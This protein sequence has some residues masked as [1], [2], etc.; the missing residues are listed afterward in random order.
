M[1]KKWK[2]R[3]RGLAALMSVLLLTGCQ[4]ASGGEGM[5]T[6]EVKEDAAQEENVEPLQEHT[7]ITGD[8]LISQAQMS[9]IAGK[10]G[11]YYFDGETQDGIGY[12]WAYDGQKI[13]NPVEQK[14]KVECVSDGLEKI[15]K[16]AGN[17]PYGLG[18]VLGDMNMASPATLT[19]TLNEKWDADR[20][21]YCSYEDGKIYQLAQ[22]EIQDAKNG[23]DKVSQ[24]S[25]QVTKAADTF[26]LLGGSSKGGGQNK[27][28]TGKNAKK[29]DSA[30]TDTAKADASQADADG[31]GDQGTQPDDSQAD[32]QEGEDSGEDETQPDDFGN[33]TADDQTMENTDQPENTGD[34]GQDET[35][36][37][38]ISIECS[39]LVGNSDLD[40]G[41]AEFV[42][43]DGWILA[44]SE[45]TYSPGETV[46]DVLKR[47][48]AETD[49]QMESNF[50]PLYGSYYIEGINQL[51]E[52]DGGDR[53]GWMYSV[54]GWFP[55]YGC[56]SYTVE[57]GDVIEW[58]YTCT[59][60]SDVGN[61]YMGGDS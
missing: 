16:A 8:G 10:K 26:Y 30:A 37:C 36:T 44:P 42:P 29:S 13:Q 9:T 7:E 50:T 54:N 51:Y 27:A 12:Q 47:V 20:V 23:K 46:F 28:N 53:S 15:Q 2:G 59:L 14:L 25:F 39:T 33:G 38:T 48:C 6:A 56:S 60:G 49:I 32:A 21:L 19:L 5:R 4:A 1:R 52:F 3:I 24:I 35:H 58:K 40:P 18:I 61:N 55:N 22:G 11:T 45:V 31:E 57:D 41:K 34:E 43:A 17:A